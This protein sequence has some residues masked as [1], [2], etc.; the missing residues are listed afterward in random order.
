MPIRTLR[1]N[2][3]ETFYREAFSNPNVQG[4]LMWGF[5]AGSHMART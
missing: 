1:A 3:M 5:W 4:I 2:Q